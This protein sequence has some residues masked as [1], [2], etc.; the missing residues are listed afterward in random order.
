MWCPSVGRTELQ[1]GGG[2]ETLRVTKNKEAAEGRKGATEKLEKFI[3]ETSGTEAGSP[4]R[5]GSQSK[6]R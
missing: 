2:G 1:E 4:K 5:E 6:C 3:Q